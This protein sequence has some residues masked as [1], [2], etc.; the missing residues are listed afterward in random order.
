[1]TPSAMTRSYLLACDRQQ[2]VLYAQAAQRREARVYSVY[3]HRQGMGGSPGFNGELPERATG[4]Y[5]LGNGYRAY[6]PVLMRFN[7]PDSWSPFGRGGLNAYAYCVGDPVNRSDPTGHFS[8][9]EALAMGIG[10]IG[11]GMSLP[12]MGTM[13][14]LAMLSFSL[15]SVSEVATAVSISNGGDEGGNK[16][17]V[18]GLALGATSVV[19]GVVGWFSRVRETVETAQQALTRSPVPRPNSPPRELIEQG[20]SLVSD[21][22][23]FTEVV[24]MTNANLASHGNN[25][26][27]L[28]HAENYLRLVDEVQSGRRSIAGAHIEASKVWL[29]SHEK[30]K[31]TGVVFNFIASFIGGGYDAKDRLTGRSIRRGS[32]GVLR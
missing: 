9:Q 12:S 4:H 3:G 5:L 18:A 31:Y 7:S 27:T 15:G 13:T 30:G 28:A 19:A 1:M 11:I 16:L 20:L 24:R 8:W 17:W 14:P 2:S 21:P 10:V 25:S 29:L 26:L 23:P 6:N 32:G 22:S